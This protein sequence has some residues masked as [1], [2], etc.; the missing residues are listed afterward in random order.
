MADAVLSPDDE[1]YIVS[2]LR[3]MQGRMEIM[4]ALHF[5]G[6]YF[7]YK[8]ANSL[9]IQIISYTSLYNLDNV[10]LDRCLLSSYWPAWMRQRKYHGIQEASELTSVCPGLTAA[11]QAIMS[12]LLGKGQCWDAE[13]C[14]LST[15]KPT[16][17]ATSRRT[18]SSR[19]SPTSTQIN[20]GQPCSRKGD[21]DAHLWKSKT[22]SKASLKYSW[23]SLKSLSLYNRNQ[24]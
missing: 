12:E 14:S 9:R 19:L 21:T 6:D 8:I 20:S 13:Y 3:H 23:K 2:W 22:G 16:S 5:H 1:I 17:S 11:W 18:A 10:G 7:P 4:L 24:V 15:S